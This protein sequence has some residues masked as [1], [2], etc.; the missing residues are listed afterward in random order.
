MSELLMWEHITESLIPSLALQIRHLTT[1]TKKNAMMKFTL[2]LNNFIKWTIL[3]V[4][5]PPYFLLGVYVNLKTPISS[6][7]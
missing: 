1:Q 2:H 6:Y 3:I 7:V 5:T 4:N